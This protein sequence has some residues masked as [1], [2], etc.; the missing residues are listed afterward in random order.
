MWTQKRA[1]ADRNSSKMDTFAETAIFD[2]RLSFANQEK[3]TSFSVCSTQT[4]V[5]VFCQ[6]CFLFAEFRKHEDMDMET[7]RH[8]NIEA[9]TDMRLVNMETCT[10]RRVHGDVYMETW[11]HGHG[12]LDMK[13]WT[14]RHGHGGMEFYRIKR[15]IEAQVI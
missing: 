7:W 2:H 12:D 11:R 15:K 8:G 13:T 5:A 1:K 4:E 10:W 14:C 9:Q 6:F 3:Q